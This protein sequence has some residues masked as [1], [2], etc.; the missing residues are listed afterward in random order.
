MTNAEKYKTAEERMKA[1]A[2]FCKNH[3]NCENYPAHTE[4]VY[5][6]CAFR[7]LELDAEKEEPLP[8]PCCGG[9][10]YVYTYPLYN[11]QTVKCGKCGASSG[12]YDTETEAIAA[13]NRRVK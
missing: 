3:R 4:S 8:C 10:A 12:N 5:P 7:W 6:L 2:S 13:W 1:Y 11:V 9:K